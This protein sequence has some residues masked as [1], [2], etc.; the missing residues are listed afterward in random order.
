MRENLLRFLGEVLAISVL[1]FAIWACKG[2]DLYFSL[3]R[4]VSRPILEFLLLTPVA[5]NEMPYGIYSLIPF[6]SLSLA[7]RE[8]STRHK[9]YK[10]L[11]GTGITVLWHII[12]VIWWYM[13]LPKISVRTVSFEGLFAIYYLCAGIFP[14]FLWAVLFRENLKEFLQH[15]KRKRAQAAA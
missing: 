15:R 13:L 6:L 10:I 7:T 8:L 3:I 11:L 9:T 4:A 2:E 5:M 14:F 12:S 1:L